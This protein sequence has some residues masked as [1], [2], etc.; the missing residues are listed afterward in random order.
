MKTLRTVFGAA[1]A[2]TLGLLGMTSLGGSLPDPKF[3]LAAAAGAL[4]LAAAGEG[5]YRAAEGRPAHEDEF[6]G[7]LGLT[8]AGAIGAW[9]GWGLYFFGR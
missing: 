7:P 3:A 4:A 6:Y 9:A 1:A 8:V 2:G 5:I